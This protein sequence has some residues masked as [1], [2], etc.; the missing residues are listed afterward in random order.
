LLVVFGGFVYQNVSQLK[1]DPEKSM[2]QR[3]VDSSVAQYSLLMLATVAVGLFAATSFGAKRW[4]KVAA[5]K[6]KSAEVDYPVTHP[7]P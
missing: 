5:P 6:D 3:I 4:L 1:S 7:R 2:L